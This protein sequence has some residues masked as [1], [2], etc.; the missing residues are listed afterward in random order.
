MHTHAHT[1]I[2][3]YMFQLFSFSSSASITPWRHWHLKKHSR[4]LQTE[5]AE[6]V[7]AKASQD[8]KALVL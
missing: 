4:L 2:H 5:T 8:G 7:E 6:G 3:I 1:H